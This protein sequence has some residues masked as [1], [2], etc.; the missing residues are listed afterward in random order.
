MT[1]R[2]EAPRQ[3]LTTGRGNNSTR[4]ES[5]WH[6]HVPTPHSLSPGA[7]RARRLIMRAADTRRLFSVADLARAAAV[8]ERTARLWLIE[9][10]AAPYAWATDAPADTPGP[11]TPTRPRGTASTNLPGSPRPAP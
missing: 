8:S 7:L 5:S 4:Q 3:P 9:L 1:G 10:D 2:N 6:T 11:R